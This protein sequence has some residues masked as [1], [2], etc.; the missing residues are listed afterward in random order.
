MPS[1]SV[2]SS[3]LLF[4]VTAALEETFSLPLHVAPQL[5]SLS[6]GLSKDRME[7]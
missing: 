6:L 2:S 1:M 3:C 7:Q 4:L 5:V